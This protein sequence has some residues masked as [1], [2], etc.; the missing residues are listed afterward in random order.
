[1]EKENGSEK[2]GATEIDSWDFN[3]ANFPDTSAPTQPQQVS[4]NRPDTD[5]FP[6]ADSIPKSPNRAP[7]AHRRKNSNTSTRRRSAEQELSLH[8]MG[9]KTE[10]S[11]FK[12][13]FG[14]RGHLDTV[15]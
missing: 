2:R 14:L 1:E 4:S 12:L 15:R 13:K 6:T 5:V 3:D 7:L 9:P 11:T 10:G 8:S